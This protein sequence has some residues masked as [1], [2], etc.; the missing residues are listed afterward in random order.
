MNK[1]KLKTFDY[2]LAIPQAPVQ[3]GVYMK[4]LKGFQIEQGNSKDYLLQQ[5]YSVYWQKQAGRVW[6]NYMSAIIITKVSFKQ[7]KVDEF[8]FYKRKFMYVL[9]N[10]NYIRAGPDEYELNGIIGKIK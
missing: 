6:Y 2:V 7:S 3:R 4:I 10:D 5:H 9:Y 1:L 8:I